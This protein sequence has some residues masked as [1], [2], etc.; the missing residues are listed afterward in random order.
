[1]AVEFILSQFGKHTD[2]SE[3]KD[4]VR[5]VKNEKLTEDD[6]LIWICGS[7]RR[8]VDNWIKE[9]EKVFDAESMRLTYKRSNIKYIWCSIYKRWETEE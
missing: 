6:Y 5:F 2:F 1:M 9:N 4:A 8:E 7:S 3:L